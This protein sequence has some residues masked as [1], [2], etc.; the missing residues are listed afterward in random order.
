MASHPRARNLNK[1]FGAVTAAADINVARRAGQR[2]RTDRQQRS[3]QD[4]LHQ[5]GDRLSQPTSGSIHY[6]GPRHHRHA[7]ARDHA[8]GHLP[9]VPDSA[10]VQHA[11]ACT[12]TCRSAWASLP[13]RARAAR[14]KRARRAAQ[15]DTL[16]E[17]FNLAGYRDQAAGLLP[18]GVRKLLD[19]AM[20]V[21]GRP[22]LL[23][24]DEP[25]SGVSADEKFRLMDMVM[26]AL[27][28]AGRHGAV[29]RAR[30]GDREP[31]HPPHPR[32]LRGPHHRR[33]RAGRACSS[34]AEVRRYVIGEDIHLAQEAGHAQA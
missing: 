13:A 30:H 18:E 34:D 21:A 27:Q 24:L 33:R 14:R 5:H 17:R 15:V 23:L 19:I 9:L 7:A 8:A 11:D 20:A 4:H 22:H 28:A 12:R 26:D 25:T 2:G 31:L 29:R 16:I 10:A 3:R 32:V 6:L 1:S